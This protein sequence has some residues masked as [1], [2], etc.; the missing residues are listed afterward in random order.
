MSNMIRLSGGTDLLPVDLTER[1]VKELR[2]AISTRIAANAPRPLALVENSRS[3]V[4]H[5]AERIESLDVSSDVILTTSGSSSG[6]PNLV[7]LSWAALTASAR[8][9]NRVIGAA[10]W[11]LTLPTHHVAG[12]QILTRTVLSG[13]DTHVCART[14]DLPALLRRLT[15]PA[16]ASLVPTQLRSLIEK[17]LSGLKTILVGGA[18]LNRDLKR[19]SE[20]LPIVTTYGMTETGGG[21]VYDGRPLPGI[22]VRL[23]N[24]RILLAGPVLMDGYLDA[25]SPFTTIGNRRYLITNDTGTF[26]EGILNVTGRADRTIITGGENVAPQKVEEILAD[27]IPKGSV[28]VIGLPDQHWGQTVCAVI[29]GVNV[30]AAHVGPSLRQT[31]K[32]ALGAPFA[33]RTVTVLR[34]LPLLPN[35]KVDMFRL[36]REVLALIGTESSWS[37]D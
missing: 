14:E 9:T 31:A 33:P 6:K 2:H 25:P 29:S 7:G 37:I 19:Q 8:T 23:E 22:D 12:F 15:L 20:H 26:R 11:V 35:G 1:S 17:D 28:T 36:H 34:E 21:C 3:S 18:H 27:A 13:Q 5:M 30:N 24:G 16:V 10:P 32:D 4:R